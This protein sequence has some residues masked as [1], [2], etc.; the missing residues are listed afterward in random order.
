MSDIEIKVVGG[1]GSGKSAIGQLI[2]EHLKLHG[3]DVT[4]HN[5]EHCPRDMHHLNRCFDAI[6][7]HGTEISV[8]EIQTRREGK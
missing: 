2:M 8:S 1:T 6:R 7:N 3:F 5:D 4:W